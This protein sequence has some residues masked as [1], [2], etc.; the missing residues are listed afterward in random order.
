MDPVLSTELRHDDMHLPSL[1]VWGASLFHLIRFGGVSLYPPSSVHRSHFD[2]PFPGLEIRSSA[3]KMSDPENAFVFDLIA[4]WLYDNE[5]VPFY[6]SCRFWQSR[7]ALD[8]QEIKEAFICLEAH[9][10]ERPSHTAQPQ[11]QDSE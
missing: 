2:S 8:L 7:H 4:S 5:K 1:H 6:T 9:F 11:A 10:S 3:S